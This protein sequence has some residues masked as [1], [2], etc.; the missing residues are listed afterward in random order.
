MALLSLAACSDLRAV[1]D[2]PV[3]SG[4]P[5]WRPARERER[6]RDRAKSLEGR[7]EEGEGQRV[8]LLL[9]AVVA[10]TVEETPGKGTIL[11][12][13]LFHKLSTLLFVFL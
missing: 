3:S 13:S 11:V 12:L 8:C 6:Q 2:V 4:T 10:T 5:A 1:E 9:A 7:R